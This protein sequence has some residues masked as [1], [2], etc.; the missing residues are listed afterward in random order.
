MQQVLAFALAILMAAATLTG[1][2]G[3]LHATPADSPAE[4]AAS[5]LASGGHGGE[6]C[7]HDPEGLSESGA[8]SCA[9]LADHCPR[10]LTPEPGLV[11]GV[12]YAPAD[13]GRLEDEV[14]NSLVLAPDHPPPRAQV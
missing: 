13:L 5:D 14:R 2:V 8:D 12:D 9:R 3:P 7:S 6:A 1:G 4:M 10:I 11:S